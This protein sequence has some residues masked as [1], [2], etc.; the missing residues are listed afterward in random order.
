MAAAELNPESTAE[1]TNSQKYQRLREKM[2]VEVKLLSQTSDEPR[3]V[4]ARIRNANKGGAFC[5][6]IAGNLEK[7]F[8][9]N[10]VRPSPKSDNGR[11]MATLGEVAAHAIPS[12]RPANPPPPALVAALAPR[13][14]PSPPVLISRE[15]LRMA[16]PEPAQTLTPSQPPTPSAGDI[17][18]SK[19]YHS[20]ARQ[21]ADQQSQAEPP[22]LDPTRRFAVLPMRKSNSPESNDSECGLMIKGE[23]MRRVMRQTDLALRVGEAMGRKD[24]SYNSRISR[25]EFGKSHPTDDELVALAQVLGLDLAKLIEARDRDRAN[26]LRAQT[27]ANT[28]AEREAKAAHEAR[29]KKDRERKRVLREEKAAAEGRVINSR[30]LARADQPSN[31]PALVRWPQTER[32]APHNRARLAPASPA[33]L[34]D[35]AS[36]VDALSDI[37]PMPLDPGLRKRWF[38][39]VSELFRISGGQ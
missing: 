13:P 6:L 3:W 24:T 34:D 12:P 1:L 18:L 8:H 28:Q 32:I 16:R 10:E 19:N 14:A 33:A 39:C 26:V 21:L 4:E 38:Q 5:R 31:A 35:L 37:V 17:A 30:M 9:W 7:F 29:K 25:I 15:A 20:N 11:P 22:E 23:R 27:E 36:L 2:L